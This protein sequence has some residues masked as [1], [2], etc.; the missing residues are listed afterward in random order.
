MLDE[1]DIYEP[2]VEQVS[3]ENSE[4]G[5]LSFLKEYSH[6]SKKYEREQDIKKVNSYTK[7]HRKNLISRAPTF[8]IKKYFNFNYIFYNKKILI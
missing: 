3:T 8:M 5:E 1:G 4:I 7:M 2:M 6:F